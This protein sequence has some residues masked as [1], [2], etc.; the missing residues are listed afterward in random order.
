MTGDQPHGLT[1]IVRVAPYRLGDLR[2]MGEVAGD[3][4]ALS[5]HR[6]RTVLRAVTQ[7]EVLEEGLGLLACFRERTARDQHRHHHVL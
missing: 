5:I 2:R 1:V 6:A 4:P 7:S 3:V